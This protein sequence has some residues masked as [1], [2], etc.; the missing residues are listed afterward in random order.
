MQI[1]HSATGQM[2]RPHTSSPPAWVARTSPCTLRTCRRTQASAVLV[3]ALR[4][5]PSLHT[6]VSMPL[7]CVM[8]VLY[9]AIVT[10]ET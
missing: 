10:G 8:E 1:T 2:R 3:P 6:C 4:G 9:G 7:H 5:E